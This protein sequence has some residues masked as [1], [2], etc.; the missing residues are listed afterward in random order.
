MQSKCVNVFVHPYY[1]SSRY[2]FTSSHVYDYEKSLEK[3]AQSSIDNSSL[4]ICASEPSLDRSQLASPLGSLTTPNLLVTTKWGVGIL[5]ADRQASSVLRA[6]RGADIIRVHGAYMHHC[7]RTFTNNLA[8]ALT[9]ND[10]TYLNSSKASP[11][12]API[13][14]PN[15]LRWGVLLKDTQ[16]G[17]PDT[18]EILFDDETEIFETHDRRQTIPSL[19]L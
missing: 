1:H 2:G 15:N 17:E 7:V 12:L 19:I 6:T 3:V 14:I 13:V 9:Y 18:P 11:I 8:L 10:H 5:R 16:R 4:V